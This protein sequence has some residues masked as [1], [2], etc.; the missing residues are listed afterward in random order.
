MSS[1]GS[2]IVH[3]GAG[4][5]RYA[6]GDRRYAELKHA[7]EEGLGAMKRGSSLDGVEAAVRYMEECGAFNAG[8]GACLTADGKVQLDA[9]VAWGRGAKG[10]GV[11]VCECTYHPVTLARRVMERTHH[12]LIAGRDCSRMA[13]AT[14]VSVE[15]LSPSE[16][17]AGKYRSMLAKMKADRRAEHD[18][19]RA[20]GEGN[21]VGAVALDRDGVPSAAVSTGGMWMKLP[22]RVGDSAVLGA[23]VYADERFGAACATGAGEEIIRAALCWRACREMKSRSAQGASRWA[24][25]EMTKACGSGT[26]G[27]ITVDLRGRVGFAY[28]TEA[29]G[30][31]WFDGTKGRVFARA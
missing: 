31:A 14:G 12:V 21:T 10:A 16:A 27:I 7:L 4:S 28:N 11:G 1:A 24:I 20:M 2:M 13:K 23:G 3:G 25:R 29:M 30:R 26:A 22:G 19:L 6:D 8:R 17:S 5:G 9:A 15:G 18:L